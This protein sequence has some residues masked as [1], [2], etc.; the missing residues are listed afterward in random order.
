M[1]CPHRHSLPHH[2]CPRPAP[3][4]RGICYSSRACTDIVSP[5]GHR[6]HESPVSVLSVLCEAQTCSDACPLLQP[7]RASPLPWNPPCSPAP[8]H[9]S[10]GL[11]RAL[12]CGHSFAFP[13]VSCCCRHVACSRFRGAPSLADK[14]VCPC[15]ALGVLTCSACHLRPQRAPP[16]QRSVAA[17]RASQ[18]R[19]SFN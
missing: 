19:T 6:P 11:C 15:C 7:H 8:T 3:A 18:A 4:P 5:R 12:H 2:L 1:P 9:R 17:A 10:P 13:G 14:R 16:W